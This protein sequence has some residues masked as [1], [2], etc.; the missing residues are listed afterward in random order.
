M[1]YMRLLFYL[2]VLLCRVVLTIPQAASGLVILSGFISPIYRL[3]MAILMRGAQK[4]APNYHVAACK[5]MECCRFGLE[6]AG[7]VLC[8]CRVS[9]LAP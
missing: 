1:I 8:Q 7:I 5:R 2:F 4:K 6:Q 3:F 9:V